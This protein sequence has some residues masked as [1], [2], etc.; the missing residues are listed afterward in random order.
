VR[1]N[2]DE[3]VAVGAQLPEKREEKRGVKKVHGIAANYDIKC[4]LKRAVSNIFE[5]QLFALFPGAR[6]VPEMEGLA[7][8]KEQ[9]GDGNELRGLRFVSKRVDA[10][11]LNGGK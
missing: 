10:M 8:G 11:C 1:C 5:F 4:I 2:D 9:N 7:K 3:H 6:V